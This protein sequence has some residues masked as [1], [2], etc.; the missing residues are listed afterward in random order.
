[1]TRASRALATT[2]AAALVPLCACDPPPRVAT[3]P[4]PPGV[5]ARVAN[6][7]IALESVE[8]IAAA[9]RLTPRDARERAIADALFAL[10]VRADPARRAR[11]AVSERAVLARSVLE[12]IQAQAIAEG[13]ATDAEVQALTQER[14]IELDRSRAVRTI[15]AVA[16]V[17]KPE[18][19]PAALALSTRLAAAVRD[20]ANARDFETRAKALSTSEVEVRVEPLPP[21]TTDGRGFEPSNTPGRL[22]ESVGNLD[23]TF[24]RAAHALTQIGEQSPVVETSFGFHVIRLEEILPEVRFSLEERRTKLTPEIMSRRAKRRLEDLRARL[25]AS[26][27]IE[28]PRDVETLTALVP[29]VP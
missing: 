4:L 8:R 1:M 23:P 13:P 10:E 15:H 7:D 29:V 21:V 18:D 27:P 22:P 28:E 5:A 9:Q 14:W 26:T 20:A 12:S 6:E 19:R 16:M 24:T 17:K 3:G 2:A 25:K 11:V